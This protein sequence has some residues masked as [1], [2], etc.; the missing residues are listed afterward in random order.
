MKAAHFGSWKS[1]IT[2]DLI[3]S[4]GVSFTGL[5]IDGDDIYW[6]ETRPSEGV[7]AEHL[8]VLRRLHGS[9]RASAGYCYRRI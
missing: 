7:S 8:Y 1:P 2:T 4:G 3:V 6:I 5:T 9:R